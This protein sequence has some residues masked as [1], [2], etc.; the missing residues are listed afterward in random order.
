MTRT[1]G[2]GSAR[3]TA[4]TLAELLIVLAILGIV[5][6]LAVPAALSLSPSQTLAAARFIGADLNYVRS[7]AIALGKPLKVTFDL[8]QQQYRVS[9]E[10]GLIRHPWGGSNRFEGLFVVAL[11]QTTPLGDVRLAAVDFG[12]H[13]WIQFGPMGEPIECGSLTVRHGDESVTVSVEPG[14][15]LVRVLPQ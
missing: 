8:P 3:P 9:D 13:T 6:G 4:F 14:T 10:D 12:G 7:Q 5:A 1:R 2:A 11:R 15:G